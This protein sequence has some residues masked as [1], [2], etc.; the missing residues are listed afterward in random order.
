MNEDYKGTPAKEPFPEVLERFMKNNPSMKQDSLYLCESVDMNGNIIDTK[1]GVNL[2][3]NYGLSRRFVTGVDDNKNIWLGSGRTEPDPASSQLT[4]YISSLGQGS[5]RDDY[6]TYWAPTY[7]RDT[8]I[9]TSRR[10][11]SRMYWDYTAGDNNE[12]EIWEIGVGNSQTTL[13]THALIYD[14]HGTQTCIVKR[15]NT[16]LYITIFWTNSVSVAPIPQMYNDGKYVLLDPVFQHLDGSSKKMYWNFLSRGAQHGYNSE[17]NVYS[18]WTFY[19]NLGTH[20]NPEY[21]D[22]TGTLTPGD[23]RE[24]EH[25]KGP[26]ISR[27]FEKNYWY[28]SGICVCTNQWRNDEQ[29]AIKSAGS[30]ACLSFE[31][32]DEPE[33]LETY[34]AYVNFHPGATIYSSGS[35]YT[36][37][38]CDNYQMK[39]LDYM[40]GYDHESFWDNPNESKQSNWSR[41]RG[42]FPCTDFNITELNMYNYITKEYDIDIPYVNY[43]NANYCYAWTYMYMDLLMNYNGA[44][45]HVY[46]YVNMLPHD[47]N[48]KPI[49]RITSF[50]NTNMVIAATDEYWDPSTYVEIP[51]LNA[52]PNELQQK[53]YYIV[54]SGTNA[55]LSPEMSSELSS[56][57]WGLHAINPVTNPWEITHA[58]TG[59][60]P[61]L[62]DTNG[63]YSDYSYNDGSTSSSADTYRQYGQPLVSEDKGYFV[64]GYMLV[65]LDKNKNCT[66]YN[67]LQEDKYMGCKHRRW[68]TETGDKIV[69]FSTRYRYEIV[70]DVKSGS[71]RT[72]TYADAANNF[73]VWTI[74]DENTLPTREDVTLVWSDAT[75]VNNN[76]CYHRYSWSSKGYLVCAKRRTETE[77]IYVN[78][79]EE[80]MP[81]HLVTDAAHCHVIEN[82]TL[83]CYQDINLT[84][85]SSYVFQIYDMENGEIVDSITINDGTTYTITGIYGYNNHVYIRVKDG[86][87]IDSTYYYNIETSALEKLSE[88]F[89]AALSEASYWSYRNVIF[90][91][92]CF[93]FPMTTNA[94][95]KYNTMV[96]DG[97]SLHTLYNMTTTNQQSRIYKAFPIIGVLNDG[98]QPVLCCSA[99]ND[100][101]NMVIDLGEL[102]DSDDKEIKH[103]P[104]EYNYSNT[105]NS[106][107]TGYND[108]LVIPFNDGIIMVAAGNNTWNSTNQVGRMWWTPLEMWM[109]MHMKGTTRT[110]NSYNAPVRFT[111]TKKLQYRLT[112]DLSR[113]LPNNGG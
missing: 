43:P 72:T 37:T 91:D 24:M 80:D 103:T 112:N 58:E 70:N 3:T 108:G 11:V 98:K 61:K 107:A 25:N 87:N 50:S 36:G 89:Y 9:W 110:L 13:L 10:K 12:Y 82:T 27:F 65:F 64:V 19:N 92:T 52:V 14:E 45:Q 63:I 33:E 66:R 26:G 90:E 102:M 7:D 46:V 49:P 95:N 76:K 2:M 6:D 73:S 16:K 18:W 47:S 88:V 39:R 20:W 67:L 74:V 40:F 48:G 31:Q 1:I 71:Q 85:N 105:S 17:G 104:Y 99:G 5:S 83:C 54:V 79:Y 97:N 113:L 29:S 68:I 78:V 101:G 38:E 86:S 30:F 53:R 62:A 93:S 8:K 51:N 75:V 35:G 56:P 41:P 42:V 32:I 111:L 81:Q 60:L 34:Y 28:L 109:K 59:V 100:R 106:D 94:D 84:N 44:E 21:W 4:T 96:V 77:F 15:P 22:D 57:N 23:P 55:A 69:M